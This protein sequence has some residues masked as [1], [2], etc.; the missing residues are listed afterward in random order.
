M[1]TVVNQLSEYMYLLSFTHR[2]RTEFTDSM[3]VFRIYYAHHFCCSF[4]FYFNFLI[5]AFEMNAR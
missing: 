2:H 1:Q 3:T 4:Y 5:V